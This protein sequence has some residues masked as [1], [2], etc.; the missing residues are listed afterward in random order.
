LDCPEGELSILIVDD[1]QIQV[2]NKKY[3]GKDRPTNVISFSMQDGD[4]SNINPHILGDV[5]I[6][7]ETAEKEARETGITM[8]E[9]FNYLLIHGILHIFG[10]DHEKSEDEEF[11]MI[12]KNEELM[13]LTYKL[14]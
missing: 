6:S 3:F 8:S 11:E 14:R 10:Y 1:S 7:V 2:F 5:V 4:F 9:R 12:K 13:D